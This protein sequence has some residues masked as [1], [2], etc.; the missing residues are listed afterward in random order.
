MATPVVADA[1]GA[2]APPPA[3]AATPAA[4]ALELHPAHELLAAHAQEAA[5]APSGAEVPQR[6][7]TT[8]SSQREHQEKKEQQRRLEKRGAGLR[9]AVQPRRAASLSSDHE[10][11]PSPLGLLPPLEAR[12]QPASAEPHPLVDDGET[13]A[14]VTAT[15]ESDG[16]VGSLEHTLLALV[17]VHLPKE[18]GE[19]R[20]PL[21]VVFVVDNSRSMER[22][23]KL[24]QVKETIF[25]LIRNGLQARDRIGLICFHESV[26]EVL[27]MILCDA[28]GKETAMQS[29]EAMEAKGK[30][31]LSA[32][33]LTG[34]RMLTRPSQLPPLS[35]AGAA[36][37]SPPAP[38][39]ARVLFLLTDDAP[40]RGITDEPSILSL[41]RD[42][43]EQAKRTHLKDSHTAPRVF[44]FNFGSHSM[45]HHDHTPLRSLAQ[46]SN[47]RYHAVDTASKIP[48]AL[49]LTVASLREACAR[50]ATLVMQCVPDICTLEQPLQAVGGFPCEMSEMHL[51]GGHTRCELSLG[52]LFSGRD[53]VDSQ[54]SKLEFLVEIH[55]PSVPKEQRSRQPVTAMH[56]TLSYISTATSRQETSTQELQL[57]RPDEFD[58]GGG[59]LAPTA[60]AALP[61]LVGSIPLDAVRRRGGG[62]GAV[63]VVEEATWLAGNGRF[64]LARRV[65]DK[66]R[67]PVT[68]SS[69]GHERREGTKA[70][71]S[72]G[73]GA[74]GDTAAGG[75]AG[76]AH[77][78]F[79]LCCANAAAARGRQRRP[80]ER[81]ELFG[82][83]H[84]RH[85]LTPTGPADR[86][87]PMLLTGRSHDDAAYMRSTA[88]RPGTS[89]SMA[90][91][92]SSG[93]CD[94]GG[95]FGNGAGSAG[96]GGG[97]ASSRWSS[98]LAAGSSLV[99]RAGR[100]LSRRGSPRT[101]DPPQ[102]STGPNAPPEQGPQAPGTTFSRMPSASVSGVSALSAASWRHAA[103]AATD[104]AMAGS[105]P[106]NVLNGIFPPLRVPE[107]Q[108]TPQASARSS[109]S[110]GGT[111][112]QPDEPIAPP[113]R[114]AWLSPR[115]NDAVADQARAAGAAGGGSRVSAE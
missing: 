46:M 85:V 23:G 18:L 42:A 40:N 76:A 91:D 87:T 74:E 105:R 37:S 103:V 94:G 43:L 101:G 83:A 3:A 22:E 112:S 73:S 66:G 111:A 44:S 4:A 84:M 19:L 77:G 113:V 45:E 71:S 109:E 62:Y 5:L 90:S 16:P 25:F 12:S 97:G 64:D 30:T 55:L 13:L 39:A 20:P 108:A 59:A 41:S 58:A 86:N 48:N 7:Q 78:S 35:D 38:D 56:V 14:Y 89:A 72:S 54:A 53:E 49:A 57:I 115:T 33:L 99:R 21:W 88:A 67:R 65:F 92:I 50:N 11:A 10:E 27:D 63:V 15:I 75:A 6:P 68:T 93:R 110:M 81:R 1:P 60:Y 80:A 61:R 70:S 98:S 104:A 36:T 107:A 24:S 34:L 79:D 31:N 29:I 95:G 51:D 47:G 9:P 32:G 8:D 102:S 82:P 96:G 100:S 52:N 28:R 2:A 114:R 17:T 69:V 26:W 106:S